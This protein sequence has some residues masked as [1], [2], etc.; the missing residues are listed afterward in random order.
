MI[1][2]TKFF[3]EIEISDKDIVDFDESILKILNLLKPCL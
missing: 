3:D 1:I 2:K